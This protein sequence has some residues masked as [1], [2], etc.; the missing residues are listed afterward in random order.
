MLT[1]NLFFGV[2]IATCIIVLRKGAKKDN[3]IL[4]MDASKLCVKNGN[5]N[6]MRPEDIDA[7]VNAFVERKEEQYFTKLVSNTDVLANESNLSVSSYVEAED[8]R[9]K[10]DIEA[11][12]STL[13][14]VTAK[15]AELRARINEIIKGL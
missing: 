9:E 11:V 8:T 12:E 7:I 2:G 14:E 1:A 5:K 10:I 4:F 3:N 15:G 13:E 6:K